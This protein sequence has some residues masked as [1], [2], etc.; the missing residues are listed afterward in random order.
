MKRLL[1]FLM[2]LLAVAG[3]SQPAFAQ[4]TVRGQILLPGGGMPQEPIR[5]FLRSGDG[6][7]NEFRFTD[8]NGRFILERLSTLIDY[9]IDVTGD[10]FNYGNTTYTFNPGYSGTVRITLNGPARKTVKQGTVS[11]ATAYKPNQEALDLHEAAMKDIDKEDM[12]AAESKLRK[13]VAKDAKFTQ[14]HVDLGA[15]LLQNKKNA[16]AEEVLRGA[17]AADPKSHVA[18]LNLGVALNRQNK[19]AD[20]VPVLREALRLQPGLVPGHLQLG[21]ALVETDQYADA[22]RE[23]LAVLKSPGEEEVAAQLYLGKLY[24]LTGQ[25]PKGIEALEKYLQKAPQAPNAG[26]VKAL[27]A[28]MKSEMAKSNR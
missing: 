3:V 22:E 26:E 4:Q 28:R 19:F 2:V 16:E 6:R 10:D 7:L 11:A 17:I 20:A 9:T 27:I 8:S 23:L 24:A 12:S 13:A 18:L 5:F 25:F 1:S 15:L 14:A 21:I